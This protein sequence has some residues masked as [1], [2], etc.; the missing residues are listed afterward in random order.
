VNNPFTKHPEE[1]GENY[2][3]HLWFAARISWLAFKVSVI[4]LVHAF[5]PF[6]FQKTASEMLE[7][8]NEGINKREL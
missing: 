7:N 3:Q 5:L 2:L 1:I 6:L 4:A 8:L